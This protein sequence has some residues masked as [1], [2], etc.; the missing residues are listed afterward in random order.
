MNVTILGSGAYG[1]ALSCMFREN[2]CKIKMWDKF[3][4]NFQALKEEYPDTSFTTN[5]KDSIANTDLIVI[6][7]PIPFLESTIIELKK[8]YNNEDILIASKGINISDGLFAH[9]II[10]KHLNVENIGAISGGTFAIDMKNKNVMGITLGTT[11]DKLINKVK[12]SLANKYL[13][14]QYTKDMIGVEICGS[15]KNVIAIGYGILTGANY[16]ESTRFLYLTKA[17]Y[18]INTFIERQN[19]SP[20]TIM[21]YAGIDDISMTSTGEKSRNHTLGKLIGSAAPQ[22]EIEAYKNTTTIE[23]LETS[24]AIYNLAKKKNINLEICTIIY[25]ILYNNTPATVLIEYLKNSES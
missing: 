16:P 5:M 17:I 8:Y 12:K 23:G 25:N 24:K 2:N 14:I 1:T 18:E 6:A 4:T 9:E 20:K 19:G 21:T 22:E 3:D 13:K 10:T 15:I 7:I 11:S